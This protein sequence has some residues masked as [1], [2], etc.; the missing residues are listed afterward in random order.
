MSGLVE[1][2]N[3]D[4]WAHAGHGVE[5]LA[6]A[7]IALALS[8]PE[9][10]VR[11]EHFDHFDDIP[12]IAE[13]LRP[14]P[15]AVES[16]DGMLW[17]SLTNG[18]VTIDPAKV[19]RNTIAPT[20]LVR[21]IK[22]GPRE[23][24]VGGP[25]VAPP[26]GVHDV[27]FDYTA[28]SLAI[29]ERVSFRYKL[30]GLDNDWQEAGPRRQ[31]FY[32]NLPPGR[33][34]FRVTASNE[35]GVWSEQGASTE[36]ETAP[37]FYQTNSF[38]GLVVAGVILLAW[39][40]YHA[41]VRYLSQ[42]LTL[43]QETQQLERER[44]ARELHDTLLQ[45]VQGLLL[46]F[47]AVADRV[48]VSS[49]ARVVMDGAIDRAEQV[50]V[51]GRDQIV[52]MR[53]SANVV[54]GLAAALERVFEDMR[55]LAPLSFHISVD[56]QEREI[57]GLV[58]EE[59]YRIAR[60]AL[61]NAARHSAGSAVAVRLRFASEAFVM[62]IADD[63]IGIPS[64]TLAAGNRPG[65][66]GLSGLRERALRIGGHLEVVS[67]NGQGTSISLTVPAASAY[68]GAKIAV[69]RSRKAALREREQAIAPN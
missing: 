48:G 57:E 29:P 4:L 53:A 7:E 55:S 46:R 58:A 12:G 13:Q 54:D 15:T 24:V 44:I 68:G 2:A 40:A 62:T 6:A 21:S 18:L 20:V 69:R 31:A 42:M 23:Y 59:C 9:H 45:G 52:E 67:V 49:E 32:T 39:L 65:H 11:L 33:Y 27:Q 26:V 37:A 41:R 17:F 1:T 3:G 10:R 43:R 19:R 34:R 47:R 51:D 38:K 61:F 8:N 25:P 66:W 14:V 35:D 56:G 28:T 30:E 36:V 22:A 63:G 50:L 60:E 64:D 16:T 5:H